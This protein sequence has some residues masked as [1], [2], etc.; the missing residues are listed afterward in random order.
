MNIKTKIIL[1]SIIFLFSLGLV[2]HAHGATNV[3]YSVGQ[4]TGDLSSGTGGAVC[5][6]GGACTVNIVAGTAT[7]NYAQT[8]N[9][10]VGDYIEYGTSPYQ[11]AYIT[12]KDDSGQKNWS[13]VTATGA[14]PTDTGGAV[15][16]QDIK[17]T[18]TSLNGA[19]AGASGA[20]KLGTG[21]LTSGAAGYILNIPCYM[22][23][24]TADS[25]TVSIAGYTTSATQYI[26]IYTPSNTANYPAEANNSQRAVGKWD[27]SKYNLLNTGNYGAITIS[28][29]V[30]PYVRIT[31]LQIYSSSATAN[32]AAITYPYDAT[33]TGEFQ[34]SQNIIVGA[35]T[36]GTYSAGI[37][38]NTAKA[39]F[40]IK[41]WDNLIYNIGAG[42][43]IEV[44]YFAAYSF[45]V[46]NNT[47]TG[48]AVG[49]DPGYISGT[50]RLKNNIVS[51]TTADYSVGHVSGTTDYANNLS[52]DNTSPNSGA[53]DCGG[54]SCRS[55]TVAFADST[56][57]D[58]HLLP[59]DTI[60][61]GSGT[62]LSADASLPF[63]VD[64][65]GQTR[66]RWDIGAD[67]GATAIYYSV[68]QNTTDHK[69]LGAGGSAPTLTVSGY[70][71]TFDVGQ[72]A[73]NMG[74]G[75][76]ITYGAN[77][78]YISSKTS[79]TVWNCTNA[80]GGTA[81]AG[82][83]VGVTS[84]AHAF[85]SLKA[86]VD[87]SSSG[88]KT[89]LG[90]GD[91]FTNNYI[92]NIPCY[93]DTIGVGDTSPSIT[94]G[95][96]T[97]AASN[98][99][100]LYTPTNTSTEANASQ[101]HKGIAGTGF[102]FRPSNTAPASYYGAIVTIVDYGRV[103][104]LEID[105]SNVTNG[106]SVYGLQ[107]I[108]GIGGASAPTGEVQISNNL[109]HDIRN[110]TIDDSGQRYAV[111]IWP[112]YQTTKIFNNIV[113]NIQN[114][115]A[116]STSQ[117]V[118]I[119]GP[120]GTGAKYNAYIYNNTVYGISN[121]GNA[122]G[123]NSIGIQPNTRVIVTNNIVGSVT[124][125]A[126]PKDY[127]G[128][129]SYSSYNISDDNT[130][131]GTGS[132]ASQNLS[133]TFV[134]ISGNNFHLNPSDT[135]ARNAGVVLSADPYFAFSTDIDGDSRPAETGNWD[136]GAEEIHS[137]GTGKPD[138]VNF[139]NKVNFGRNVNIK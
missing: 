114:I 35:N 89:L 119:N 21:D 54:H 133:S 124:G 65:D 137:A 5:S 25:S 97:T 29:M 99:F 77:I 44:G 104:G 63:T 69:T 20:T 11:K 48:C 125:S 121:T 41:I 67:E 115:S 96:W 16:L 34:F 130:A 135:V 18:F 82:V 109:I 101:R 2:N 23:S 127:Y 43:G 40:V 47:V 78:C 22:D 33:N 73:P 81:P 51:A 79:S 50:T 72:T 95:G 131:T 55:Q 1:Y 31:G 3:Y 139:G 9:I 116:N 10:G 107:T 66:N 117:A 113:Y 64:I 56:N 106:K 30:T 105:G 83:G 102:F 6:G 98:Y 37:V 13:V 122:N 49:I 39:G 36:S 103:D 52:H 59:T 91:L 8:G 45:L 123:T 87:G 93:V 12:A 28:S 7:V 126:T 58:Y 53:T 80:T 84:V 68:G 46:Y 92:L 85:A 75:D 120:T 138:A 88:A 118:G 128:T 134:S 61:R 136:I 108:Y 110:S 62:N 60:A 86:S 27:S 19:I 57:K 132:K 74:V 4:N 111:G 71:A 90:T 94:P 100:R 17:H 24:G 76:K 38:I 15:T 112:Q 129:A 14:V 26:N 42:E 32:T 70:T